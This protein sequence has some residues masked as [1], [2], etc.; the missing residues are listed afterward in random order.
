MVVRV[1]TILGFTTSAFISMGQ[2]APNYDEM[3]TLRELFPIFGGHPS[4]FQDECVVWMAGTNL[5]AKVV[6]EGQEIKFNVSTAAGASIYTIFVEL[7]GYL[8]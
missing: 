8:I 2:L 3:I 7:F 4:P 5:E 6:T 1:K